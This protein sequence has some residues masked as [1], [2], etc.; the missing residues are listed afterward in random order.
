MRKTTLELMA[1]AIMKRLYGTAPGHCARIDYFDRQQAIELC[2]VIEQEAREHEIAFHVLA[3]SAQELT[4]PRYITDNRSAAVS[5]GRE[6][7]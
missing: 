5:Q 1:E 7:G 3:S 6:R 4:D 2:D